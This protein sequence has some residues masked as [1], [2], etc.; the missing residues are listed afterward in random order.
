MNFSED[1]T[2][3]NLNQENYNDVKY[4]LVDKN[5]PEINFIKEN[6]IFDID[7]N[8]LNLNQK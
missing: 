7:E 2:N 8:Y 1:K 5:K 3:Y 6:R 4:I